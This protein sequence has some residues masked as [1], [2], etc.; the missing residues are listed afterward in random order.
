M[1]LKKLDPE[2]FVL[3]LDD[4]PVS[5]LCIEETHHPIFEGKVTEIQ[6]E[7]DSVNLEAV[8][9]IGS[10][11]SCEIIFLR[12]WFEKIPLIGSYLYRK[13]AEKMKNGPCS[14]HRN[15]KNQ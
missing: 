12:K 8:G 3:Y 13:R 1:A 6:I 11:I 15:T 9:P 7:S 10:A 14:I 4:Q 2:N 5:G